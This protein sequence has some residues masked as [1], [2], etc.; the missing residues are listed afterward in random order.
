MKNYVKNTEVLRSNGIYDTKILSNDVSIKTES[1][2]NQLMFIGIPYAKGWKA[3]IDGSDTTI[4]IADDMFMCIEVPAGIH[5]IN[6]HYNTP[7]LKEGIIISLITLFLLIIIRIIMI[8]RT[9]IIRRKN[10]G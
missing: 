5:D 1:N 6:L 2:D 7:L 3:S 10:N 8:R 9:L 4:H